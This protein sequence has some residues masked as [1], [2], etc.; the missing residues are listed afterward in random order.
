MATSP[1]VRVDQHP[2]E[3]DILNRSFD[4]VGETLVVQLMGSDGAGNYYLAK[5]GSDGLLAQP[6]LVPKQYDYI[7]IP[8]YNA[9]NDPLTVVYK[10]GGAS[11]TT[12][13]TLTITYDVTGNISSVERT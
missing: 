6:G 13:A 11:G 5:L 12:V 3:Q 7:S 4:T 2:S 9:N 1:K 8:S 10:T